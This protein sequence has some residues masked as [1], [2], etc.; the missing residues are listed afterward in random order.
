MSVFNELGG[1]TARHG[2]SIWK[3]AIRESVRQKEDD[4]ALGGGGIRR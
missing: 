2:L 1:K 4:E 3:A